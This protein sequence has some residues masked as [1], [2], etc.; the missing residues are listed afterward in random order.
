MT[1]KRKKYEDKAVPLRQNN[2]ELVRRNKGLPIRKKM[3]LSMLLAEDRRVSV[4]RGGRRADRERS[5]ILP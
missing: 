1:E 2:R 5:Q 3:S 4:Q